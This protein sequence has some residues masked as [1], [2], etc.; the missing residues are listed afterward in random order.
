MTPQVTA[1]TIKPLS[2]TKPASL[3]SYDLAV[4]MA[5]E[6]QSGDEDWT[7][8]VVKT[9]S[10]DNDYAMINVYDEDGEFVATH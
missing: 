1:C 8:E 9:D 7:Y 10:V 3:Y 4:K 5:A 2:I 6:L